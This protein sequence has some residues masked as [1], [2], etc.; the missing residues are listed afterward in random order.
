MEE[1]RGLVVKSTGSWYDIETE[2]GQRISARLKGKFRLKGLKSTNP[3]AVGDFIRFHM[4]G[5]EGVIHTIEDRKNY[6]VRRSI[7]LSKQIQII[8]ANVDQLFLV[9]T[10]DSPPTTLG[11][12]DRFVAGAEAYR[13]PTVLVYNKIDL[14]ETEKQKAE[15]K[16]WQSIYESA[17]YEQLEVSAENKQ[18]VE[19]L[20]KKMVGKTSIFSGHSGVGKST[21][22]NALDENFKLK[23]SE[24]S[25]YHKTGRHT[26]T[27]A[28]LFELPFGGKIID[29]PGI[30]GFGT[31]DLD[32]EVL[33]HYFP[34]MRSRM[35]GC[36]FNNCVHINEPKCAIKEAV[37]NGEITVERYDSYL[38][39]YND[40]E[41]EHHRAKGVRG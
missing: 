3:V 4:E 37:E 1:I 12:V 41:R 14:Y 8:A 24:I 9:I 11:F 29:T 32:N 17:G 28:E 5:E 15:L 21:L 22:V 39:I 20:K 18:G 13:I 30:K 33:A 25:D 26:T 7:N 16:H 36:K 27:F 38:S 31:V 19:E 35:E 34:E 2:D 40:D 10:I 23:T 6:I